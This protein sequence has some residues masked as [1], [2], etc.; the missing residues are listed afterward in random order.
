MRNSVGGGMFFLLLILSLSSCRP[1]EE[2]VST[3]PNL[4]LQISTDTVLFDTLLSERGS[5]T[6]R[7]RIYNP[8]KAAVKFDEIRLGKGNN[9]DYSLIINGKESNRI[10][11]ETLFGKDSLQVLVSV[12]IDPQDQNLPYLVKDSVVFDWNGNSGHVKL[13]AYGQDAIYI[14][15]DT[16]CNVTWTADRPYVIYN[17]A[18]VDTLC[19]LNIDPGARVFLDNDAAILV[20]GSLKLNGEFDNRITVRNSR[21]DA[22]YEV[23]PGQWDAIYLLEGSTDNEVHY[24]DLTNGTIGLRVGTPDDDD[25][26]DLIITNSTIGHMSSSGILAFT[27]EIYASNTVV[28]NCRDYLVGNFAGG[29]YQYDHCT[30][31]NF[32]NLF[33][34]DEPSVQ[35]SDNIV[36]GGGSVISAPLNITLR[37]TIIWGS[38]REEL[39]IVESAGEPVARNF[40]TGILRSDIPYNNFIISQEQNFPGFLNPQLFDYH[41]DSLSFS[42]DKGT[43]IGISSDLDGNIRVPKPDLGAYEYIKE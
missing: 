37:N 4:R 5:I 14:N 28:Y 13:V 7:F 31:S 2:L 19:T 40:L 6:R 18:L 1:D 43:E 11:N 3:S 35:F 21:F 16:L 29:T 23:A 20:K 9:S 27:S 36:V 22:A 12:F 30:L 42:I 33:S 10:R 32:P 26:F 38:E 15:A 41:L 39:L 25:D 24:S 8:N 34:R 17:Y